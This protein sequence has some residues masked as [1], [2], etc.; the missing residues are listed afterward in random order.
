M[1]VF[2][3]SELSGQN[4]YLNWT[5]GPRNHGNIQHC[6]EYDPTK[7]GMNDVR[8]DINIGV[9]CRYFGPFYNFTMAGYESEFMKCQTDEKRTKVHD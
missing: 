8:C 6:L 5:D 7:G 1:W 2:E 9:A 4:S 3:R